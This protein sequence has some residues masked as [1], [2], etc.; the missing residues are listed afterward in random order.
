MTNTNPRRHRG[1]VEI[2]NLERAVASTGNVEAV[3]S[4]VQARIRRRVVPLEHVQLAMFFSRPLSPPGSGGLY[5]N[6]HPLDWEHNEL[7][8][9]PERLAQD[10]RTIQL[11][12]LLAEVL[13][14]WPRMLPGDR[15]P[16]AT[17]GWLQQNG[18]GLFDTGG[19]GN[20][21]PVELQAWDDLDDL[22]ERL[23]RDAR[24][25]YNEAHDLV[26]AYVDARPDGWLPEWNAWLGSLEL[27]QPYRWEWFRDFASIWR[28]R[29]GAMNLEPHPL[30]V[31]AH[32][33]GRSTVEYVS[34][35]SPWTFHNPFPPGA[36]YVPYGARELELVTKLLGG[37]PL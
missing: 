3:A 28:V 13:Q 9:I 14:Q 20:H 31:L 10:P 19:V 34:I 5:Y 16:D 17:W 4:L 18:M 30:R 27:D 24:D 2:R 22:A 23:G 15:L 26:E 29:V 37:P 11:H 25:V 35:L 21:A 8:V 32:L 36:L 12:A 1:D 6:W 7:P 33:R